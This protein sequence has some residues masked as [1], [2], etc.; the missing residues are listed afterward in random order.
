M[1]RGSDRKSPDATSQVTSFYRRTHA[2]DHTVVHFEI[3]ANEPERA[4]KFYRE[5]FGWEISRW[6]GRAW[7]GRGR[8]ILDGADRPY[9]RRWPAHPPRRQR[10]AHAP[11]VPGP[12]SGQLHRRGECRRVRP[13][14]GAARSQGRRVEEARAGNGVVRAADG[15]RGEHLRHLADRRDRRL[16]TLS[17]GRRMT[18]DHPAIEIG[19]EDGRLLP[20]RNFHHVH[21]FSPAAQGEPCFAAD[22]DVAHPLGFPTRRHEVALTGS[23]EGVDRRAVPLAGLAALHRKD[24]RTLHAQAQST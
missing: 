21:G 19:A 1:P 7:R 23:A 16:N 9:R 22:T 8:R 15:H 17:N 10:W 6:G 14:S 12:S 11:D 3:P 2:M 24:A 13:A 18:A 4:A 5:L 20:V